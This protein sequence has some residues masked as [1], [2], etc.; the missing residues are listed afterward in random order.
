[1]RKTYWQ[2]GWQSRLVRGLAVLLAGVSLYPARATRAED[3]VSNNAWRQ[4]AAEQR[5]VDDKLGQLVRARKVD[6]AIPFAEQWIA[7]TRRLLAARPPGPEEEKAVRQLPVVLE[8]VIRWLVLQYSRRQERPNAIRWQR[9]LADL[10]MQIHG[11]DDYRTT[12]ASVEVEYFELLGKL[13]A[14]DARQLLTADQQFNKA[15]ELCDKG[16]VRGALPL[17]EE[18][19]RIRRRALGETNVQ[20]AWALNLLGLLHVHQGNYARAEPLYQ[21]AATILK[22]A[23]GENHPG[24]IGSLNNLAELYR[25]QG[26]YAKAE[27]L[28]HKA[29][30]VL[31][32]FLGENHPLYATSLNNLGVLY[33]AQGDCARAIP[34]CRRALEIRRKVLGENH[35]DY[36]ASLSNLAELYKAQEQYTQAEPLCRQALEIRRKVQGENHPDY[37]SS[38]NNLAALYKTQGDYARAEPLYR[39]ALEID[40]KVLG[41]NHPDYARDLSNLAEL[42]R[43]QG[44]DA[45]ALLL[46]RQALEIRR[47]VLGE[48][49]PDYAT[50]LNNLAVLYTA[51]RDYARAVQLSQQALELARRVLGENHPNYPAALSNLAELYRTQGDCVRAEPLYRQA[52]KIQKKVQGPNH[53]D[54][55][56]S[57]NNLALLYQVQGDYARAEPMHQEASEILKR[58]LGEN[59]PDYARSL[60]NLAFVLA[61]EGDYVRA[62]LLNQ[63]AMEM[64]TRSLG[65]NHPDCAASLSNLAAVYVTQ[66]DYARAEPLYRQAV[67]IMRR[68]LDATAT[69]QSERQQLAMLQDM[70]GYLDL[71]LALAARSGFGVEAVYRETLT[72]KGVVF[73]RQRQARAAKETPELMAIF[74]QLQRVATQLSRLAWA[75]PDPKQ[76]AGWRERVAKLSAEKDRLEAEL[77]A[78]SAAYRQAKRQVTLDELQAALPQDSVLVDFLEYWHYT[79]PDKKTGAKASS[80]RSLAVFVVVADRPVEMVP[81]GAVAPVSEAIDTWRKTFGMSPQGMAAGR[82]LRQRIWEPIEGKL[83]GA[84]IVLASPDG[85]LGRLP[86]GALPGKEP[87]KYLLEERTIA[88]VPVPQLIPEI[89]NEQGRK[90]LRKKLLLI[91]NVDY[92]AVA[93][94]DKITDEPPVGVLDRLFSAPKSTEP[95]S[96]S[97]GALPRS[98][99]AARGEGMEFPP[100]PATKAE[101]VAI[102]QLYSQGFSPEGVTTLEDKQATKQAFRSEAAQ[103]HYLHVATHGF[104]A[105]A[106]QRSAL[107]A[108]PNE[109]SRFAAPDRTASVGGLYPGLLSG[110]VLA[111]ANQAG[112][113]Q[114][115]AAV[116]AD[117]G[118]ATAEEIGSLNLEGV[119]L[120]VLSACE[121]GLGQTSG[122]E[123]LLGLQRAFQTASAR[124]VVASLW[125]VDDDGTR[126]LMTEFYKNLWEKKLG[127]LEALRQ[128]QLTM[129][130]QYDPKTGRLRGRGAGP[131][132]PVDPAKLAAAEK[133]NRPKPVSPFYW[134]AFVLSGDW[135]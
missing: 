113:Q 63:K 109:L 83:G 82:L 81:L 36:V 33:F 11:Q 103:H 44:D 34:L 72:W 47:N 28:H 115:L 38:L 117:D 41:E 119:E 131:L 92:G 128:A 48:N 78:R 66:G 25:A 132:S 89:V 84:K 124:T 58:V 20:T 27:S 22:R 97:V 42:Y 21:Q 102:A 68:H 52:L 104:F 125:E 67:A 13:P 9:E 108:Q 99:R 39:Q 76:E 100:L 73:R 130:R 87:G 51:Q 88:L 54:Y 80:V 65:E 59:H 62:Q 30:E 15:F 53:A 1:M 8:N 45:R 12:D 23:L 105:P 2:L 71:Y 55:A 50:S 95:K 61:A 98:P 17:A 24:Y 46:C 118:I 77:S 134:A 107:A 37:A 122:G 32:R 93:D 126:T 75:T 96:E 5:R 10:E 86:L 6:D 7:A 120:V 26:D 18:A 110:L 31:K 114:G 121:T 16:D 57:L 90:Q 40:R 3:S 49:H 14:D 60:S 85:V 69:V 135:R 101:I 111:G 94:A 19:L 91:G 74:S 56:T 129:L 79:P 70:R 29:S 43:V 123:G 4:L 127:K 35:A 106:S 133:A 116:D 112:K 64:R